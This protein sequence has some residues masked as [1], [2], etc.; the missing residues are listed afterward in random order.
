MLKLSPRTLDPDG[1]AA[2]RERP[3]QDCDKGPKFSEGR[4]Y[5]MAA[6]SKYAYISSYYA[7]DSL[8]A[9]NLIGAGND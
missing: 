3:F 6:L 8:T 1:Y 4:V 5:G 7:C 2:P 9:I